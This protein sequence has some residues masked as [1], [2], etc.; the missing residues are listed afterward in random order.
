MWYGTEPSKNREWFDQHTEFSFVPTAWGQKMSNQSTQNCC[1][2]PLSQMGTAQH[3]TYNSATELK[4]A[5]KSNQ[6]NY[7]CILKHDL[8]AV[9]QGKMW[10]MH[11]G[12]MW[13]GAWHRSC[14]LR[15][16]GLSPQEQM[17]VSDRSGAKEGP[18][19][20]WGWGSLRRRLIIM[21]GHALSIQPVTSA[22]NHSGA[23]E[24]STGQGPIQINNHWQGRVDSKSNRYDFGD[25]Q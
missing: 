23:D 5:I 13:F 2:L 24:G 1:A 10:Q 14:G 12:I 21:R 7:L 25:S 18:C 20:F 6:L 11:S 15:L 16:S 3:D 17:G 4:R 8:G 19:H 22:I 9:K